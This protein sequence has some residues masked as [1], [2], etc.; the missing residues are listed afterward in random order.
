MPLGPRLGNTRFYSFKECGMHHSTEGLHGTSN[1]ERHLPYC[2]LVQRVGSA[3]QIVAIFY[4]GPPDR[5]I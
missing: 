5:D 4:C 1:A 2:I 3:A